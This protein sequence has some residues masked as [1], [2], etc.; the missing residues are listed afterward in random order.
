MSHSGGKPHGV[1]DRGQRYEVSYFDPAANERRV[2][3]WTD[4]LAT[5]Q[6]MADAVE[7]HPSWCFGWLTDRHAVVPKQAGGR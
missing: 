6:R 4:D 7:R 2:M 3:G 5:A 1:G